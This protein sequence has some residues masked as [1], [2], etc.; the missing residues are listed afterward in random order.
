MVQAAYNAGQKAEEVD[1]ALEFLADAIHSI[2]VT[3]GFSEV[4]NEEQLDGVDCAALQLSAAVTEYLAMAIVYYT[5]KSIGRNRDVSDLMVAAYGKSVVSNALDQNKFVEAKAAIQEA[6]GAYSAS[7]GSL[8]AIMG[9]ELLQ[10]DK[11]EKRQK[12]L[13]WLWTGEYWQTHN[14]LKRQ[15]V[16]HTGDWFWQSVVDI[17]WVGSNRP[18]ICRGIR[19][20]FD[21]PGADMFS[22][23]WEVVHHVRFS[24]IW[25]IL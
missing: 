24:M 13:Q 15:R 12:V 5:D 2:H 17:N 22:W 23:S 25:L 9:A 18:L 19:M 7:M 20:T 10:H 11:T 14:R 4:L 16:R 6:S 21:L 1:S 8:T 3:E